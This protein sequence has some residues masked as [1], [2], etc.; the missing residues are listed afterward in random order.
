MAAAAGADSAAFSSAAFATAA[1]AASWSR[2]AFAAAAL[3]A[4]SAASRRFFSP[5]VPSPLRTPAI[6]A[7]A[8]VKVKARM[9]Q[10][11]AMGY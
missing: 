8:T 1:S 2:F 11:Y 7:I 3:A 4:A 10:S 6:G 9:R 5:S